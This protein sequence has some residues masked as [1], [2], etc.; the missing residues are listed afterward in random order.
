MAA[1]Q[2]ST[3][4]TLRKAA[5]VLVSLGDQASAEL[6]KRLPEKQIERVSHEVAKLGAVSGDEAESILKEFYLQGKSANSAKA[7]LAAWVGVA[8]SEMK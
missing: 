1:A 8:V 7:R 2:A 3:N 6:I 5:I 4:S